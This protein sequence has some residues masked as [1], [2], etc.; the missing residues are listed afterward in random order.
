MN[1]SCAT[2]IKN[3]FCYLLVVALSLGIVFVLISS[4]IYKGIYDTSEAQTPKTIRGYLEGRFITTEYHAIEKEVCT[5]VPIGTIE[6]LNNME[7]QQRFIKKFY[8]NFHHE[9]QRLYAIGNK[10]SEK[11][12]VIYLEEIKEKEPTGRVLMV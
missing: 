10:T 7:L 11:V 9:V 8:E 12:C 2:H 6:L 4:T 1:V 5:D 3:V